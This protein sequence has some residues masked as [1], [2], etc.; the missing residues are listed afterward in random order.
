MWAFWRIRIDISYH[1]TLFLCIMAYQLFGWE[2]CDCKFWH[3]FVINGD[4]CPTFQIYR[5]RMNSPFCHMFFQISAGYTHA[6]WMPLS[7]L[8]WPQNGFKL[9]AVDPTPEWLCITATGEYSQR[10]SP[11][12][13]TAGTCRG[14]MILETL[15]RNQIL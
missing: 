14:K 7:K 15:L 3:V 5:T 8:Q 13:T 9:F 2:P 4:I 10:R 6:S 1:L 11:S 12:A